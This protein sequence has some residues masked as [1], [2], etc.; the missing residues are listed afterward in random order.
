MLVRAVA[1]VLRPL[2]CDNNNN[3]RP[4]LAAA[5]RFSAVRPVLQDTR[6]FRQRCAPSKRRRR[7]RNPT[8]GWRASEWGGGSSPEACSDSQREL[9]AFRD[10]RYVPA[11]GARQCQQ[12][13]PRSNGG[14]IGRRAGASC[15]LELARGDAGRGSATVADAW[16]HLIA[17]WLRACGCELDHASF[18]VISRQS[19]GRLSWWKFQWLREGHHR[20]HDDDPGFSPATFED[21]HAPDSG[22]SPEEACCYSS[23]S[24][25]ARLQPNVRLLTSR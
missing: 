1:A 3:K 21:H 14:L 18:S 13:Q 24:T 2:R 23:A 22:V 4:K 15:A 6:L 25:S 16:L 7:A 5:A 8:R 12:W 11:A 19:V 17:V 20:Q 10:A 9:P